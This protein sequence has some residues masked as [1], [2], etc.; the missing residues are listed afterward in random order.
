MT[1]SETMPHLQDALDTHGLG[2]SSVR[3]I[4][5]TQVSLAAAEFVVGC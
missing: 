4:C 3:F 1:N 2:L 5:G